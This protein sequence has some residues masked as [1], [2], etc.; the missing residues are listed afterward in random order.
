MFQ[1][2]FLTLGLVVLTLV[3][4]FIFKKQ[5]RVILWAA[6]LI[7][8]IGTC[9]MIGLGVVNIYENGVVN[10]N[11]LFSVILAFFCSAKF[12]CDAEKTHRALQ[13]KAATLVEQSSNPPNE[14]S[15]EQETPGDV[16]LQGDNA[17]VQ[18]TGKLDT[19]LARDVFARALKAGLMEEVDGHYKWKESKALLAYMCGRIYCGDK[20]GYDERE[21]KTYWKFGRTEFFPETELNALFGVKA[22][23]QS[24]TNRKDLA[25]PQGSNKIDDL[26]KQPS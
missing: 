11:T 3:I 8:F 12:A 6:A 21:E 15:T 7:L 13:K 5:Q 19:P 16:V 9:L 22:L 23:G 10:Q 25:V 26:F 24:R 2:A 4:A 20:P 1:I 18:L 14:E 17:H